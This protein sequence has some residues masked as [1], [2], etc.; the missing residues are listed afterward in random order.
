MKI[1]DSINY[2]GKEWWI[3]AKGDWGLR[4][5]R[6]FGPSHSVIVVPWGHFYG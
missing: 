3:A 4:L 5:E 6:G 1:G 2:G